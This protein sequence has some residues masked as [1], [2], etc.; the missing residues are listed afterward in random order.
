L[1]SS[2]NLIRKELRRVFTD[3]RLVFT[4]HVPNQ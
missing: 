2:L 4:A 1:K 3:Y